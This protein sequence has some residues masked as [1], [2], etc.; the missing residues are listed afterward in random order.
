AFAFVLFALL[1]GVGQF[2]RFSTTVVA[3]LL[4]ADLGL[5]GDLL[6]LFAACLFLGGAAGQIPIGILLDRYGP[7][8]AVPIVCLAAIVGPVVFATA[9][10]AGQAIAGRALSGLGIAASVMGAYIV[11][12][13]WLPS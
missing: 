10:G 3:P 12:A 4:Q 8:L 9:E 7:R 1:F 6:G 13:R 11:F 2:H 5:S